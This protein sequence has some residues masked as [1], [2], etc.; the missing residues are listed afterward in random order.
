MMK[1][2]FNARIF[3]DLLQRLSL[4]GDLFGSSYPQKSKDLLVST[5]IQEARVHTFLSCHTTFS[6]LLMSIY[7][8]SDISKREKS[9]PNNALGEVLFWFSR[10]KAVTQVQLNSFSEQFKAASLLSY[11]QEWLTEPDDRKQFD[12]YAAR[13]SHYHYTMNQFMSSL[14]QRVSFVRSKNTQTEDERGKP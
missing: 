4:L 13:I 1:L 7:E 2:Q 9:D 8:Q 3:E 10:E 12:A 14:S 5:V 11:D 6:D